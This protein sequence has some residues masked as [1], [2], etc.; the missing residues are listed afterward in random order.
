[1]TDRDDL[2]DAALAR[3]CL[4][5]EL[6]SGRLA[7]LKSQF[8]VEHFSAGEQIVREGEVAAKLYLVLRGQLA[9]TKKGEGDGPE[10]Q[11]ATLS[12]GSTFGEMAILESSERSATV[13]AT[14]EVT[15]AGISRE[16]FAELQKKEET[17]FGRLVYNLARELSSRLR[18]T[19]EVTVVALQ[20]ELKATKARSA[21]G[22]FSIYTIL[23]FAFYNLL[24]N[25][26]NA[27]V[28]NSETSTYISV[29]VTAIIAISLVI[30]MRSSGYPMSTYGFRVGHW[31]ADM[32]LTLLTTAALC[33]AA[34]L[35][36]W[37]LISMIPSM[38][39]ASVFQ[40]S[41]G[42]G[43]AGAGIDLT[44]GLVIAS[45]YGLF[46]PV[47]E[48]IV[49]GALQ[50]SFQEF[51]AGKHRLIWAIVLSNAIF[52]AFHVHVSTFLA[53]LAMFAGL[54][55]GWLYS[56]QRSLIGV[57]VSHIL[58]GWYALFILGLERIGG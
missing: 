18:H 53:L 4:F 5:A 2:M 57:S 25:T 16:A 38:K 10:Y 14:S 17:T 3:S 28:E 52:G 50:S 29:A 37:A 56:R 13:R 27:L 8:V 47:Q 30:M 1:M 6:A 36:K 54:F 12:E 15:L 43:A 7:E 42:Y 26:I 24:L 20:N 46:S 21:M 51:L 9:V 34:T 41:F 32:R 35:V 58:T 22:R 33:L 39:G 40:L 48:L 55:W 11:L 19:N 45:L 44:R 23:L 49:R 31:K